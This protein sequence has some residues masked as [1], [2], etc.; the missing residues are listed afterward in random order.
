[1]N[2]VD[3]T[4]LGPVRVFDGDREVDLGGPR[5]RALV[6]RTARSTPSSATTSPNDFRSPSAWMA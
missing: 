1:M 5:N 4:V 2:D 6:G 3:V